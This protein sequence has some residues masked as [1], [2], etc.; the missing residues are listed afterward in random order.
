MLKKA[1]TLRF[2]FDSEQPLIIPEVDYYVDK[3]DWPLKLGSLTIKIILAPG[4]TPGGVCYLIENV[5]FSGDTL[6][7]GK[8]VMSL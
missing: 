8:I 2:I 7:K 3:I 5:L 4:H 1:N 6:F